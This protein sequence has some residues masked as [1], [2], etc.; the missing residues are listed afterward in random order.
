VTSVF[1]RRA[2]TPRAVRT[3]ARILGTVRAIESVAMLAAVAACS[4]APREP[5][6]HARAQPAAA[7]P[8]ASA[9]HP[10][11][12]EAPAPAEV[13][14]PSELP[15][16][17]QDAP[18]NET[19]A[20]LENQDP[21]AS[22]GAVAAALPGPEATTSIGAPGAG[23]LRGAA[24]LPKQGPGFIH[25]PKRPEQARYATHEMI[26][27]IMGAAAVVDAEYPG[28]GLV[29]N[30]LSLEHGGPI[31]QHGSHQNGR[32]ADILFYVFDAKGEPIPSVGVPIDPS[33]RGFDFKDL[34]TPADDQ[35]VRLDAKRTMRFIAA[36]I[37]HAGDDVQRIF[38]AEHVRT[39]LLAEANR[40][41]IA[42]ATRERFEL[43]SCQPG[44]PHDDHMH[45]RF[46]CTAQDMQA[47]CSDSPPTY[48]FR[49]SALAALGLRPTVE[50]RGKRAARQKEVEDRTTSPAE[51]RAEAGPMHARVRQFLAK[52]EAWL[53]Q[54]HPG[55]PFCR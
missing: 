9:S 4:P 19:E 14:P 13:A 26:A 48:P 55:R 18:A 31:A 43:L 20:A 45:V 23:E 5:P 35:P 8:N 47:G 2:R 36:L 3:R 42:K 32:D 17:T 53:P 49:R 28:S 54:P 50:A 41:R 27:A 21:E 10:A 33:G 29:V 46:H 24:A 22:D 6:Q 16:A 34:T 7:A 52:R 38:I 25:N 51:A 39:L 40:A 12:S 30:D 15:A 1:G 44:T 37:E 11:L